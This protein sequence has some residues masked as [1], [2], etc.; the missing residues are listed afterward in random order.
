MNAWLARSADYFLRGTGLQWW[1]VRVRRGIAAGAWWTLYPLSSYWRGTQEMELHTALDSLGD[2]RGWSCWDIGAHFG[3]YAIGLARRVGAEGQVAAFE[4]NPISYR[5]LEFHRRL[6]R[7]DWMKTFQAAASD[8]AGL[9]ELCTDGDFRT[10]TTR[11][12]REGERP[13]GRERRISIRT[14]RL[15]DLVA[16]GELRPPQ[17]IK[18][19]VEGHGHRTLAGARKTL[20]QS[21]PAMIVELHSA[22]EADGIVRLI[23]PLDYE[24]LQLPGIE[25][26]QSGR[27]ML[28]RPRR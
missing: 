19:D 13:A 10:T 15:D 3:I 1:P 2:I 11:L 20:A 22:E 14:L 28:F 25:P 27:N 8:H 5:R 24:Q 18:V 16:A 9:D 23:E 17:F 7:L 26:D 4:P 6:N 21:R 12:R